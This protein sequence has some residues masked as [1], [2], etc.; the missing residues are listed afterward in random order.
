MAIVKTTKT[1][2]PDKKNRYSGQDSVP[3]VVKGTEGKPVVFDKDGKT[4]TTFTEYNHADGAA[5]AYT[6]RT[7]LYA[8]P[9]RS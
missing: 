4:P 3:W 1:P 6:Q 5:R 8:Q 9:V 2:T 7:G